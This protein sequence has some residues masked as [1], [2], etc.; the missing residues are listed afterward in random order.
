LKKFFWVDWGFH[1]S[2]N[3]FRNIFY[4]ENFFLLYFSIL[5]LD[6]RFFLFLNYNIFR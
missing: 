4:V 6:F 3:Q 2:A 1:L 5:L